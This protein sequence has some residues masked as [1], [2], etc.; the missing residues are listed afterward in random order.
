MRNVMGRILVFGWSLVAAC[1]VLLI[2]IPKP[3][4]LPSWLP[5]PEAFRVF[6]IVLM[7]FSV[8]YGIGRLYRQGMKHARKK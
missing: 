1:V 8:A 4:K 5:D 3:S 7:L 2:F 6:L